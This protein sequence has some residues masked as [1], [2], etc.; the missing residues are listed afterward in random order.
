MAVTVRGLINYTVHRDLIC[1]R[2]LNLSLTLWLSSLS[3]QKEYSRSQ[4]CFLRNAVTDMCMTGEM[5]ERT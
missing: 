1:Q 2:G 3:T 5:T 4:I